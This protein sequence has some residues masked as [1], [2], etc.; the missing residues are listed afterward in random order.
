MPSEVRTPRAIE[1]R[2]QKFHIDRGI[3]A[4]LEKARELGL[5]RFLAMKDNPFCVDIFPV[6][7]EVGEQTPSRLAS[8]RP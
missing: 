7:G 5:N 3:G 6:G 2:R 1:S 8:C 4:L